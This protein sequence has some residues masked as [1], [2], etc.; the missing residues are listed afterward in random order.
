MYCIQCGSEI[1]ESSKFCPSCGH[2]N[3]DDALNTTTAES[4]FALRG[5]SRLGISLQLFGAALYFLG[6]IDLLGLIVV[7]GYVFIFERD[8]WLK[9]TALTALV[10]TV[11]I[12][13][14]RVAVGFIDYVFAALNIMILWVSDA[15]PLR[16][17]ANIGSLLRNVID[18]TRVVFLMS[19]GVLTLLG[20][21]WKTKKLNLFVGK[22]L[23]QVTEKSTEVS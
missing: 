1:R 22:H 10:I 4:S 20:K 21:Q 18:I 11:A 17:P 13:L 14:L 15:A 19:L 16:W 2:T 12:S 9:T 8:E 6:M 23:P 5:P 7:T 3:S